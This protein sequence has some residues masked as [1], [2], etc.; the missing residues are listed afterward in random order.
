MS[1]GEKEKK[2]SQTNQSPELDG[3]NITDSV[4]ENEDKNKINDNKAAKKRAKQMR[5]PE[6]LKRLKRRRIIIS[7]A[8]LLV[9]IGALFVVPLTRWQILNV[10]GFRGSIK[11]LVQDKKTYE[12]V[13]DANVLIDDNSVGSTDSS[14]QLELTGVRLGQ[15]DLR[16]EKSGYSRYDSTFSVG[17]KSSQINTSI[18]AIGIK[19]SVSVK[20]WLTNAPVPAAVIQAGDRKATTDEK[21]QASIIIPPSDSEVKTSVQ[22]KDYIKREVA[23]D[24]KVTSRDVT[25]VPSAKDYFISK[26][27]GKFDIYSTNLDGTNQKKVI[28]ATGNEDRNTLQFTID[29]NNK[30]AVLIATRE[31]ERQNGRVVA[32]IY[33][34]N[35]EGASLNKFDSGSDVYVIG[36]A[37]DSLIYQKTDP[38]L[39]YDAKNLTSLIAYNV[40]TGIAS[41]I[42]KANYFQLSAIA[43]QSIF[44]LPA[45]AY[46]DINP[47]LTA[48][49]MLTNARRVYLP[50]KQISYGVQS[51]Y[52]LLE[53]ETT[54]GKYYE[55]DASTGASTPIDRQPG[56][57]VSFMLSQNGGSVISA[58]RRDGKGALVQKSISSG[59]EKTVIKLGGLTNPIRFISSKLAVVRIS[60]SQETADYV[61]DIKTGKFAKIDDVTDVGSGWY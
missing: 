9:A 2:V 1:V 38:N 13:T 56:E 21:G 46:R 36:W 8:A 16:V 7:V 43:G 58:Q 29:R 34:V 50:G 48:L 61:V 5:T 52:G 24:P 37:G 32:G 11:V 47:K 57:A 45:D 40:K 30:H 35:L 49:D 6:E 39:K 60:T 54:A 33:D 25:L 44:Y 26:R 14:G 17:L 51:N 10:F 19:V 15:H 4:L 20:D 28:S 41:T 3:L 53:V 23:I 42:S 12:T 59:N 55:L 27:S 18:E 22:A 31:I